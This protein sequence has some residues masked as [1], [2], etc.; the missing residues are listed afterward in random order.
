MVISGL[1]R[2]IFLGSFIS[3]LF[4]FFIGNSIIYKKSSEDQLEYSTKLLK[5]AEIVTDQVITAFQLSNQLQITSCNDKDI[6]NLR[7]L[8]ADLKYVADIGILDKKSIICTANQGLLERRVNLPPPNYENSRKYK[9]YRNIINGTFLK[10]PLDIAQFGNIIVFT[11]TFA[12][13]QFDYFPPRF[14]YQI[15]TKDRAYTFHSSIN[16]IKYSEFNN[17]LPH[18]NISTELCSQKY[19]YC[20]FTSNP[21]SGILFLNHAPLS[22]LIFISFSLGG[23]ISYVLL[24]KNHKSQTIESRLRN[25]IKN[26]LLYME[27]QPIILAGTKEIIGFEALARW[28]DSIYGQVSPEL[29]ISISEKNCFYDKLSEFIIYTALDEFNK[30]LKENKNIYLSININNIEIKHPE[31]I[32]NLSYLLAGYNIPTNQIKIEI[33]ERID[34]SSKNIRLF[35]KNAKKEGFIVSLDD[36]GTGSSNIQWLTEIN[37]DEIKLDKIFIKGLLDDKNKIFFIS[38]LNALSKLNK[39]LVFEGVESENEY[40]YIYEHNPLNLIQ[41]WYFYKSLSIQEVNKLKLS[42]DLVTDP[43]S[44]QTA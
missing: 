1:K 24:L 31:F 25:A 44:S 11:S 21:F 42:N 4:F 23:L 26:K 27:Y 34:E 15:S 40:K 32:K 37:F 19:S 5:H 10:Q 22:V 8:V 33:T 17:F 3:L 14:N 13:D 41:G 30:I 2:W 39:K 6:Q 43:A 38:L 16:I 35:S 29:F 20:V 12:F 7:S 18:R 9:F 28:K 36:F